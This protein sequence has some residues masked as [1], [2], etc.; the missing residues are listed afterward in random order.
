MV[1]RWDRYTGSAI[2]WVERHSCWLRPDDPTPFGRFGSMSQSFSRPRAGRCPMATTPCPKRRPVDA[3][4]STRWTGPM[5]IIGQSRR[6]TSSIPTLS[7]RMS[8]AASRPPWTA[9]FRCG[10]VRPPKPKSFVRP[11]PAERGV[12][13]R[14]SRYRWP[15]LRDA[16]TR[17]GRARLRRPPPMLSHGARSSSDPCWV[18]SG[19]LK[20]RSPWPITCTWVEAH[21]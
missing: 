3:T 14:Q 4:A 7:G 10:A 12:A 19:P 11:P 20:I 5:R 13:S 16:L 6:S 15:W 2:P 1:S 21:P 9:P 17:S 8:M 18:T